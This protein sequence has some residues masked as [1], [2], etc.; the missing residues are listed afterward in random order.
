MNKT[1]ILDIF[2]HLRPL[3][4][5]LERAA[6]HHW[7]WRSVLHIILGIFSEVMDRAQNITPVYYNDYYGHMSW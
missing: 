3:M 4:G 2:H 6:H 7:R 5:H 1:D